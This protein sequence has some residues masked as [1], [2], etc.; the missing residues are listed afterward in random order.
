M[1]PD[2]SRGLGTEIAWL[3]PLPW[4]L[5]A[6]LSATEAGGDCCARSFLNDDEREVRDPSDLLYTGAV[7]QFFALSDDWGLLF[8]LSTQQGP[9]QS[10]PGARA[11]L[12]GADLNL[13][14]RPVADPNRKS[15]TLQAEWILRTRDMGAR[16]VRDHGGYAHLVW[17]LAPR[18][19]VGARAE[20]TT[21]LQDDPLD[22]EE[23]A[24]RN[25][26]ALQ[27][28]FYPSHFSRLRLQGMRDDAAWRPKPD[29]GVMLAFEVVGG[30]HGAHV[31]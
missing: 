19:E 11:A 5:R 30:A 16:T 22:P 31:Y 15:L 9:Q 21:G 10:E 25:R 27:V 17:A 7:Q 13:R 26:N 6:T 14:W 29:W 28:T 2:G 23:T 12:Y 4:Y 8:G 3:A 24:A 18:W 1:G 20:Y